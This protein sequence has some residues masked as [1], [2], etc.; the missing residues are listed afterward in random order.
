MCVREKVREKGDKDREPARLIASYLPV[1]LP[2]CLYVS[3]LFVCVHVCVYVHMFVRAF[4]FS[5]FSL[6]F[7]LF[8]RHCVSLRM[9]WVSSKQVLF[10]CRCACEK[11]W[12]G[13]PVE[14]P[15]SEHERQS[16]CSFWWERQLK[17]SSGGKDGPKN[18]PGEKCRVQI[19][20][21]R[22]GRSQ[23]LTCGRGSTDLSDRNGRFKTMSGESIH[24]SH[25]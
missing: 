13:L 9:E 3:L 24:L 22:K 4:S 6:S 2:V 20:S 16:I 8:S 23:I 19:L 12:L 15:T 10:P 18:V 21:S 25:C 11:D 7:S 17:D 14:S 5:C 1:Y